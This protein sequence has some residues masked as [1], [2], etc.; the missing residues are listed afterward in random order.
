[1][2]STR[3][4]PFANYNFIVEIDNIAKAGFSEVYGLAVEVEAVDYREGTD[5]NSAVRKLPGRTKFANITL[6]RGY[7][8]DLALWNW[9]K[10][11][12]DGKAVR[13]GVAITLLDSQRQ[14]AVRWQVRAAWPCKYE[15]PTLNAHGNDVAVET[16]ELCHEGIERVA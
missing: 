15:G 1:M 12:L 6:K 7:T 5:P 9:M 14:P 2:S 13:A 10:T 3:N 8:P 4:D 16:L 11:V